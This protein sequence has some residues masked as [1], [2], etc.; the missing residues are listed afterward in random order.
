MAS[1]HPLREWGSSVTTTSLWWSNKVGWHRSGSYL[2]E[3]RKLIHFIWVLL[4]SFP[5]KWFPN[6]FISY[7]LRYRWKLHKNEVPEQKA[8]FCLQLYRDFYEAVWFPVLKHTVP[9]V[10]G[11]FQIL[12]AIQKLAWEAAWLISIWQPATPAQKLKAYQ[13][14]LLFLQ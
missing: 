6:I 7:W 3:L 8:T 5:L 14:K 9:T 10:F 1:F 4:I 12:Q 11:P 13:P 2:K